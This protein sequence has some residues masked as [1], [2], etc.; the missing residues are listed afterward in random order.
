MLYYFFC[1][2]GGME[3]RTLA[4]SLGRQTIADALGVGVTAVNNA[5]RRGTLPARWYDPLDQYCQ[6]I[7]QECPRAAFNF[8]RLK[9]P[10]AA[11]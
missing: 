2:V 7:G 1:M 5:V 8:A 3:A 11:A 6:E 10:G 4:D 9:D